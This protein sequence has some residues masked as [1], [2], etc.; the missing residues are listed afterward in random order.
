MSVATQSNV[1]DAPGNSEQLS[2]LDQ[3]SWQRFNEAAD[4]EAFAAA[5]LA[6]Q[7][8][9]L[10]GVRSGM[11]ALGKP[12][13]GPFYPVALWPEDNPS[14]SSL[15]DEAVVASVE[16]EKGV[17]KQLG[18]HASAAMPIIYQNHLYGVAA[19][20]MESVTDAQLRSAMRQLQWGCGWLQFNL[21]KFND[22]L[23]ID[24]SQ[25]AATAIKLSAL[26]L[27]ADRFQ[28]A[29]TAVVSEWATLL[30]CDRVALGKRDGRHS[31]VITLSHSP[32][33]G[34]NA[35]LTRAIGAAMDEA[36][37]QLGAMVYPQPSSGVPKVDR[38]H[39]DLAKIGGGQ[40]LCTVLLPDT[41]G[42]FGAITFDR[43]SGEA[44]TPAEM[45]SVER[46]AAYLGPVLAMH[47]REDRWIPVK[48]WQSFKAQAGKLI[49]PSH[50]GRKLVAVLLAGLIAFMS[51][52]TDIY[53]VQANAVLEGTVER[54]TV[55]PFS[56]YIAEAAVRAGDIVNEGDLLFRIDDRDLRLEFLKWS[57]Q[58]EQTQRKLRDAL[59]QHE[60]SEA[61]VL[62]AQLDQAEAQLDLTREQ[63]DRTRVTAPFDGIVVS[64]DLSDKL[65]APVERGQVLFEIAPLN[66]YRVVMKVDEKNIREIQT[67]QSGELLLAA[68]PNQ[69]LPV[70]VSLIT[71]LSLA[72]D[73]RNTFRVDAD[74][75]SSADF[76]RPGMQ[77]S[78]RID[79]G[80]RRLIWIWTHELIDWVRLWFWSWWP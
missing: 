54:V 64:G 52:A 32:Q 17:V 71:P 77:G 15:L 74:L 6:L 57:S 70:K 60:R 41:E 61:N 62:R 28:L 68:M 12:D 13:E 35:N 30:N 49:G 23:G 75:I 20:E 16:A 37:D 66:Q 34:K 45:E 18:A 58:K 53:R 73:G 22:S 47:Y 39:A 25:D 44:F 5:W 1:T 11:V 7:C 9:M 4:K 8:T 48:I 43:S 27:E 46:I 80:E 3:A 2:Y 19:V 59:A 55:A 24:S 38:A 65:G 63:I 67:G 33:F 78:A 72:A 36:I 10:T 21:A 50:F 79:I 76:L 42:V 56:G 26:V 31:K 69:A 14:S 29:A 40:S 51:F